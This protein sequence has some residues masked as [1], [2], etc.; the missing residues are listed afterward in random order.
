LGAIEG[1]HYIKNGAKVDLSEQQVVD[2]SSSYGN[3]YCVGGSMVSVYKYATNTKIMKEVDYPY[4][5]KYSGSCKY[6]SSKGV[7][8]VTGYIKPS[9]TV[10]ALMTAVA[11]QPVS[12]GIQASSS[13][14]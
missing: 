12:V 11:Q 1:L 10:T 4:V 14:M 8:G 13:V 7:V 9:G 6:S 3:N 5:R 2:C